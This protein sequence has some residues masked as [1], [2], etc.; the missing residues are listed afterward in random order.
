MSAV[1][2]S[3]NEA[4]RR[5]RCPI[6]ALDLERTGKPENPYSYRFAAHRFGL[7]DA[8]TR[9][10]KNAADTRSSAP[11]RMRLEQALGL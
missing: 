7:S 10:L 5:C 8:P 2:N 4:A 3:A 1:W 9:L 6:T 11:L